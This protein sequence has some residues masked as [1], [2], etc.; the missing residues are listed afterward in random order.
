MNRV[1]GFVRRFRWPLFAVMVATQLAV[2]AWMIYARERVL[3]QGEVYRFRAEPV[4]PYDAFRGRYVAL[5]LRGQRVPQLADAP[6]AHGEKAYVVLARG[7]DGY[8]HFAA[9]Q[10]AKPTTAGYLRL[11]LVGLDSEGLRFDL[12]F[13]RYYLNEHLAPA[14]DAA[15]RQRTSG[16]RRAAW[17]D[18]RVLGGRGVIEELYIDGKPVAD[19]VATAP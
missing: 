1:Q 5:S 9:A 19:A 3:R 13:D 4:D 12:P 17:I 11:T 18:L 15:F 6:L 8:A 16:G 10:R 2:P 14:A 7:A